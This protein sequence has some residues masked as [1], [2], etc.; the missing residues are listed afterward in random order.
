MRVCVGWVTT[1]VA[2]TRASKCHARKPQSMSSPFPSTRRLRRLGQLVF[3]TSLRAHT[4]PAPEPQRFKG[5]VIEGL[6]RLKML[7]SIN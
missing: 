3:Y 4:R 1:A 5:L 2:F 6:V 7:L